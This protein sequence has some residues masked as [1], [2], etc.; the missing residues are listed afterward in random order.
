MYFA[1]AAASIRGTSVALAAALLLLA[2]VTGLSQELTSEAV[3]KSIQRGR[4]YLIS[5]QQADGSW[6][7]SYRGAPVGITSLALLALINSGLTADDAAVARGL[8]YLRGLPADQPA[9]TYQTYE[10]AVMISALAAARDGQRDKARIALLAQRLEDFQNK[11]GNQPGAWGYGGGR[12]GGD[13][14]NSQFAILGLRDAADAGIPISRETW[15]RARDHWLTSQN[16]DGGWS[17]SG[18]EAGGSSTGSMTVAGIA[19][20]S[21]TQSMLRDEPDFDASG[22]PNCCPEYT[23]EEPLER[24]IAWLGGEGTFSVGANPHSQAW[25]LYYLYGLERAGRLTGRRF[26]GNHD[27]YR[28]GAEFLLRFQRQRGEWSTDRSAE[29]NAVLSTSF[30][31]LFLSKGL[32]P[33]LINKARFGPVQPGNALEVATDNWNQHHD[34]IR[35][36]TESISRLPRWPHL[37]TWQTVDL[38]RAAASSDV[39]GLLQ[40]P[41]LYLSGSTAPNLPDDQVELLKRFVEQGGFIFAVAS[42]EGSGFD[43]GFRE[44]AKRIVPEP[45]IRLQ[46]LSAEHP[47]YRS[48]YL[49]DP[50]A[51]PLEGIDY[52]CRTA[53]VYSPDDLACYWHKWAQYD[54]PERQA[55]MKARITRAMR[56]GT[57]VVAYATGREPPRKLD[58]DL[59]DTE[60]GANERIRRGLLEVA[61]L[62]HT[63]GWDTAPRALPNLL[64][65]LNR[66][67]GLAASTRS[68]SLPATDPA[69]FRFPVV[70][71]HG[72]HA[73]DLSEPER[74][75]L[76]KYL[77]QGGLLFADAC[78]GSPAFDRSFRRLMQQLFPGKLQQIPADHEMFTTRIGH[79]IRTVQIRLPQAG[80]K[81]TVLDSAGSPSR[82]L[83]E[84][85]ELNGRYGVIY[86]RYDI[87]C[88]LQK[89]ASA[90]CA[91]Y[92]PRDATRI[93][94]NVILYAMLQDAVWREHAAPAEPAAG[95][96]PR[97]PDSEVR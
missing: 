43:A 49:L 37:M 69:L 97:R 76:R 33:V 10:T 51:I 84:G 92:L 11:Q 79:D 83:L 26:F 68:I 3:L 7:R 67:V 72:R 12:G 81:N 9:A 16:R 46:K 93:A 82:P 62:R 18:R 35:H 94:V 17:Y 73:F 2:P 30:C 75:R 80:Q 22:E 50:E 39:A 40:A 29:G 87:S 78:C 95:D 19:T 20:L 38:P 14:S 91:G 96:A 48:E 61:K 90:A 54:P 32:S 34:D 57:N 36:L 6:S 65:A 13:R 66:T 41:I 52:G 88:A 28:E 45:D 85:V 25:H 47:I 77:E 86:S 63:G 74:D 64:K 24:A 58:A 42:C 31:L 21:I 5:Q 60:A 55:Q 44:L 53:V 15:R 59:A 27:W 89:Q 8:E 56:I 4:R 1:T 70:A 71:M 23:D